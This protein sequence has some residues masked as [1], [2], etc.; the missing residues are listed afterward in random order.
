LWIDLLDGL[1][2]IARPERQA[3]IPK[4]LPVYVFAG[5]E[6]PVNAKAKELDQLLAA[7]HAAGLTDVSHRFY[8]GGRHEILNETNRD[9]VTKDLL[10]WL[11][12]RVKG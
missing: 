7:Y 6:D 4:S 8:P 3:L 9:E 1:A 5:A 12:A 2:A 10:A 11:D